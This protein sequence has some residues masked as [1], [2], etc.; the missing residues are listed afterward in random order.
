MVLSLVVL[1]NYLDDLLL[2]LH[3]FFL[4]KMPKNNWHQLIKCEYLLVF[5]YFGGFATVI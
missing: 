4:K 5:L 2:F 3:I 1:C